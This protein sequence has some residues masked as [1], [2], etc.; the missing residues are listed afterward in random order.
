MVKTHYTMGILMKE[1]TSFT[2]YWLLFTI[3][4]KLY[5]HVGMT[6]GSHVLNNVPRNDM[7]ISQY[8][9]K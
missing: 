1:I 2:V 4:K 3:G 8:T 5:I 9:I 6:K 7:E